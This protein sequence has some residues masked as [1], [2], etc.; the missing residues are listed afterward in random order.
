MQGKQV[1]NAYFFIF[2]LKFFLGAK[3]KKVTEL[4]RAK[5]KIM[6]RAISARTHH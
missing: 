2:E 6:A 3:R 5:L 4:S 1:K